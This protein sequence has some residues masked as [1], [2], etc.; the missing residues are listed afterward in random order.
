M[1]TSEFSLD[2]DIATELETTLREI[3]NHLDKKYDITNAHD[4][5]TRIAQM[6]D[7]EV[8]QEKISMHK[9]LPI[10]VVTRAYPGGD[11]DIVI[12]EANPTGNISSDSSSSVEDDS[13]PPVSH[14]AQ[15][16]KLDGYTDE[17]VSACVRDWSENNF[18]DSDGSGQITYRRELLREI[19]NAGDKVK[20]EDI[21]TYTYDSPHPRVYDDIY[22][23]NARK[24]ATPREEDIINNG[25]A[26]E[27][28]QC[29]AREME[30][31]DPDVIIGLGNKPKDA[32]NKAFTLNP[33]TETTLEGV[34]KLHQ[35]N[36]IFRIPE[37]DGAIFIPGVHPSY[38]TR[39]YS[40]IDH[41]PESF[42]HEQV[43]RKLQT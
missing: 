18:G 17:F 28:Y 15:P 20:F 6:S 22:F 32:L 4:Y 21:D 8:S 35:S 29:F 16:A 30:I 34:T 5:V 40:D 1:Q 36:A 42:K 39:P 19:R 24:L 3:S 41:P 31:V 38:V 14:L 9:G 23:T 13:T 7:T 2:S 11:Q 10:K 27:S 43:K 25:I 33:L 12:S 37:L 26:E